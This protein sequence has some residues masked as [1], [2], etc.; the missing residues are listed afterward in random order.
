[1]PELEWPAELQLLDG[2]P[3]WQS[4]ARILKRRAPEIIAVAPTVERANEAAAWA[5]ACLERFVGGRWESSVERVGDA[6]E[7]CLV[8]ME[9]I[10]EP[11]LQSAGRPTSRR[12]RPRRR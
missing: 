8:R 11:D 4:L 9:L 10:G 7:A 6:T 5:T 12:E 3:L 1:M 2:A